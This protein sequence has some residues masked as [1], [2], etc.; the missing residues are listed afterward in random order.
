VTTAQ[1]RGWGPGWPDC[2]FGKI[3]PLDIDGVL[4]RGHDIIGG[5]H[6]E[7]L[8]FPPG[9]RREIHN[10]T[11]RLCLETMDRG[12]ELVDGW[13]WGY[14]CRAIKGTDDPSNHSWGLAV[15]LN[16]PRN[17]YSPASENRLVTDMPDWMP[18][19]W[20]NYGFGWGGN[21]RTVKDAM[22][23]E[24]VGTPQ[25]ARRFTELAAERNLG[26]G[27]MTKDQQRKLNEA[28]AMARDSKAR[29]DGVKLRLAGKPQP[30][31][32]GPLRWGWR[33]ADKSLNPVAVEE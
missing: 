22:H 3:V 24:F 16:A 20:A 26:E 6:V 21:Y 33:V 31:K 13:C 8:D 17:R 2:Q 29:F 5:K 4:L 32:A 11:E 1:D 19:L 27:Y 25:D 7:I 15:D 30:A 28:L 18:K 10:L 23:Y 14:A 12:Y 9:V